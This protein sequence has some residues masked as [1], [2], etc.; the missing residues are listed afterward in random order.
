MRLGLISYKPKMGIESGGTGH[1][2]FGGMMADIPP[3][4]SRSSFGGPK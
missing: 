1:T 2:T 4:Y 3:D